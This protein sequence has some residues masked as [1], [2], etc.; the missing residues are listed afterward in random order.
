[1]TKKLVCSITLVDELSE[2]PVD[3]SKE[4]IKKLEQALNKLLMGLNH[5]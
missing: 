3:D 5:E 2:T 4:L 1:M